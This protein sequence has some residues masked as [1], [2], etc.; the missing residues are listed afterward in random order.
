MSV[1]GTKPSDWNLSEQC[2]D[3][4]R[5]RAP[6]CSVAVEGARVTVRMVVRGE[7][8]ATGA[9]ISSATPVTATKIAIEIADNA[10]RLRAHRSSFTS[11]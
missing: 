1:Y 5:A 7:A 11:A 2:A 9:D 3:E 10:R 8:W 6:W 4:I